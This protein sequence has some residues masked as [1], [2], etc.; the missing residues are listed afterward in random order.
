MAY[1]SNESGRDEVYV[2]P[3]PGPGEQHT[4]ST[5]GG[6]E[7]V[8]SPA[9]GE[10]FYRNGDDVMLVAFTADRTFHA[11]SPERL[12]AGPYGLDDSSGGIGGVPNYDLSRDGQQLLMVKPTAQTN[13]EA[14]PPGIIVVTH[15]FE[16]LKRL[17]PID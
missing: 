8:W 6:K 2:R 5:S 9:G 11:A 3:Y 17:V 4:I 7:P 14:D 12:F 16:E 1:V 13:T 10:L 15:W